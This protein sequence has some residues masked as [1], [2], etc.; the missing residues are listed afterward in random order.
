MAVADYLNLEGLVS[1][2]TNPMT[3]VE[4]ILSDQSVICSV[5]TSHFSIVTARLEP[6]LRCTKKSPGS[7]VCTQW[8]T[9]KSQLYH[10]VEKQIGNNNK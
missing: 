10:S 3:L 4:I 9:P 7:R 6:Q 1:H 5:Y 2:F 8:K